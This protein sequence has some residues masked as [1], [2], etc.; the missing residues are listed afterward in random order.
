M[1]GKFAAI[2]G[3]ALMGVTGLLVRNWLLPAAP[4]A[5]QV[6]AAGLTATRASIV[7]V[8]L[9]FLLGMAL[10]SRVDEARGKAELAELGTPSTG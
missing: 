10:F 3:P 2:I 4:S 8:L 5:E 6:H 9:L 1:L 7:S